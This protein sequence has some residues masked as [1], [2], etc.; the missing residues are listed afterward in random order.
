MSHLKNMRRWAAGG[1]LVSGSPIGDR[2]PPRREERRTCWRSSRS[3]HSTPQ[4]GSTSRATSSPPLPRVGPSSGPSRAARAS[5]PT[6]PRPRSL[7]SPRACWSSETARERSSP[8]RPSSS[9]PSASSPSTRPR[10]RSPP[11]P[12]R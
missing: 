12:P 4:L 11:R 8:R 1:S 7:A 2:H 6:R 3:R 10:P 5:G 9:R